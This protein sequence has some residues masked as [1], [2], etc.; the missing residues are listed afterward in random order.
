M[1]EILREREKKK[2]SKK[3]EPM[4]ERI[5]MRTRDMLHSLF[6]DFRC[7]STL[8]MIHLQLNV[9]PFILSLHH[10]LSLSHEFWH[11]NKHGNEEEKKRT[12]YQRMERKGKEMMAKSQ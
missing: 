3:R 7:I 11:G 8:M 9:F 2:L 1:R 4:G 6:T 10:L 12:T 5:K